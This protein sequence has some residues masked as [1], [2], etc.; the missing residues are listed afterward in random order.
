[1][2]LFSFHSLCGGA[3]VQRH[4]HSAALPQQQS[5]EAV[6]KAAYAQPQVIAAIAADENSFSSSHLL[7]D[8]LQNSCAPQ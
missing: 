6:P 1:M 7:L 2:C 3:Q 8:A 5:H 4:Q